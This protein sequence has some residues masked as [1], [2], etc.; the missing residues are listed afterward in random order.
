MVIRKQKSCSRG[1]LL[2]AAWQVA[3][4]H[5]A[6]HTY[7][8]ESR[9]CKALQG[10]CKGFSERQYQNAF[11]QAVALYDAAVPLVAANARALWEQTDV[12]K[13]Q[14]PDFTPLVS[15]LRKECPGFRVATYLAALSWVFFWHHLK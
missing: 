3:Q 7:G 15:K 2:H 13:N 12:A 14:Y 11:H 4:Q 5:R 9:A 8:S 1:D 10:R 6:H